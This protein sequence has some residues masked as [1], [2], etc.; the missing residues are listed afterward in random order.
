MWI[1]LLNSG[2]IFIAKWGSYYKVGQE[3]LQSGA[4]NYYRVGQSLL[5]SRAGITKQG[6]FITY[7]GKA[8]QTRVFI[9]K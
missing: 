7:W 8:L 5:E 4:S 9:T 2:K 6:N 1:N 3:L